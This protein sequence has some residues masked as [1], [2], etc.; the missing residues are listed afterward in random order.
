LRPL[1]L[2]LLIPALTRA[3][4]VYDV[5]VRS[6]DQSNLAPLSSSSDPSTPVVRR[7]FV[8]DG[9]VRI[10]DAAAK[11][12]YL[13]KERLMYVVDNTSRVIH[14]LKH[15]TLSEVAAHYADAVT[16]LQN[17]AA[18]A[19]PQDREEAQRK[20]NDM[21]DVS[22]RMRQPVIREYRVTARFESVDGHACRVWEE[23]EKDSKRLEMCVASTASVSGG[24]DILRGMKTLSQFRQG[25]NFA[26]GV[27]FGLTDWWADIERL[28][29]VPILIREYKYDSQ[30][31]EIMLSGMHQG[32]QGAAQFDPPAGY[33]S[34][35]GPDYAQWYVR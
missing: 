18:V 17:A 1:L 5:S 34:Q 33:A 27:E 16:Q 11:T 8:E 26:F 21:K 20:A 19:V 6:V 9:K 25:S 13:F 15:A 31:S 32:V 10:G 28:G 24:A 22:E 23:H 3:G 7:Y 12:V 29:G 35:D 4:V 2:L 30:I 14:V